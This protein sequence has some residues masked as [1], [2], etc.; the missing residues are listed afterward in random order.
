MDGMAEHRISQRSSI[1][2]RP[3]VPLYTDSAAWENVKSDLA[4]LK[5]KPSLIIIDTLSRLITGLDENSAKDAGMV[6]KF[7]EQ[8][9]RYFEC[10]V[11]AIHHTGKDQNKGARG[12]S[13][14]FA[15]MDTVIS[16]K[17]KQGGTELRVKKQKDADVSGR[18]QLLCGQGNWHN[19]SCWRVRKCSTT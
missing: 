10:F 8:L 16:T 5:A 11:L 7:M 18:N 14:F 2:H 9:A 15:N 3:E 1:F 19:R 13:A 4:E 6:T 17:L 12:S